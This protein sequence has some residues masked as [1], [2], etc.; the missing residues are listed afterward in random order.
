MT[1]SL[2]EGSSL[3]LSKLHLESAL[4]LLGDIEL[5][6]EKALMS[7]GKNPFNTDLERIAHQVNSHGVIPYKKL[8]ALNVHALEKRQFDDSLLTLGEIGK[9]AINAGKIYSPAAWTAKKEAQANA[10]T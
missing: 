10:T 9:L 3:R 1:L 7:V 4:G 5:G 6:M 8:F 2:A